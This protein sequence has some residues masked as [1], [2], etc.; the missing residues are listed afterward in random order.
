MY[1]EMAAILGPEATAR[2]ATS[3]RPGAPVLPV[4]ERGEHRVVR[5]LFGMLSGR[6]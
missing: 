4:R 3:A 6:R 2:I 1:M 5:R